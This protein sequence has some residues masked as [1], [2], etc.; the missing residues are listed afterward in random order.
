MKRPQM[1]WWAVGFLAASSALAAPQGPPAPGTL[2][3]I[4]GQATLN[5]QPVDS[6]SVSSQA[7]MPG[8]VLSTS[9]G[10]VEMLLSPGVF[11]RVG[12]NSRLR[13]IS[14]NLTD[15]EVALDSGQATVEADYFPSANHLV[16]DQG[17]ASTNILK[18]G[19]Y[20][21]NTNANE[22]FVQVLDG[23]A[24]VSLNGKHV[25]VDKDGGVI[26]GSGKLKVRNYNPKQTQ[27]EALVRWSRL[28]SEY[29]AEANYQAAQSV[30]GG[31]YY[32][33]GYVNGPGYGYGYGPSW[34]GPGWYWDAGFASWA[35][36]PGD[37]F[38]Y[39][40]FGWGFYSPAFLYGYG[41]FYGRPGFYGRGF[42]YR[43][44]AAGFRGAV[45]GGGFRGGFAGG[46]GFHGGG[47][48]R[49]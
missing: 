49:R 17:T 29:E 30:A 28:R 19:L 10:K 21:L 34:Y 41:G 9:N 2:N 20:V 37:G 40:P 1:S 8:M 32:S 24:R 11:L 13:M 25:N 31:S 23:K 36:L 18:R 14:S 46:G 47:G 44:P 42:G 35:F 12:E 16:V 45:A 27:D 7:L 3:Y 33:P 38:L 15:T 5:G 6:K 4:E 48:G 22:P 26:L 39:S 43:A